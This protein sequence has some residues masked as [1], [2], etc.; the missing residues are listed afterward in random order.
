MIG[1]W[2]MHRFICGS[3]SGDGILMTVGAGSLGVFVVGVV[4]VGE[5]GCY[6]LA[7]DIGVEVGVRVERSRGT[8]FV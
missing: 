6:W 8:G 4:G 7:F 3:V 2:G 1:S 5:G